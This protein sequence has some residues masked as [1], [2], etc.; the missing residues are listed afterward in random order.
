M[1]KIS[2]NYFKLNLSKYKVSLP[3]FSSPETKEEVFKIRNDNPII[4]FMHSGNN[5]YFWNG[6]LPSIANKTI[7]DKRLILKMIEES[8]VKLFRQNIG[9]AHHQKMHIH[10]IIILDEDL[11]KG[12]FKG[13]ELYKTFNI[14]FTQ[15]HLK[16]ETAIGFT[17]STK[18]SEKSNWKREDFEKNNIQFD[19]LDFHDET[20]TVFLN[21]KAKY[22]I[23]KHFNYTSKLK[24]KLDNL[25]AIQNEFNDIGE[26]IQFYILNDLDKIKLPNDLNISLIEQI[27]LPNNQI[28]YQ[29]LEQP[30]CYFFG[31]ELPRYENSHIRQKIKY[32]KPFTYDDFE[33]R[34]ISIQFILP[35][36]YYTDTLNFF[37]DVKAELKETFKINKSKIKASGKKLQSFSI[38]A[39]QK[40]FNQIKDVDLVIVVVSEEHETLPP[41]QS[42]YYFCKSE[43]MK[44]GINTQEVQIQQ[45]RK[46][47][48][49]KKN[50]K[51]NY[52]HHNFALNI[53]AKLGGM[54]WTIKPDKPKNELVIG[55]GATTDKKGQPI[56]G[57]A[58]IF[59]GDGKYLF[60]EISSITDMENYPTS[61]EKILTKSIQTAIDDEILDVNKPFH[62]MFHVF[63]EVGKNNEIKA[64]IRTVKKFSK[65]R[66]KY[67]FVHIGNGHNYRFFTYSE[68]NQRIKF[69]LKKGL[70]QNE[71]G[72]FIK[73]NDTMGFLGLQPLN[74]VFHKITIDERS[75]YFN[76][77]YV[78]RQIYQFAELSHT[79]YNKQGRPV[80]IKYPQLMAKFAE[81]FKEVN[82]F[83][84]TEI[85]M[86][87]N[88]LWFI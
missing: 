9:L 85:S 34:V 49:D 33:N 42:P 19:D 45:I 14:H 64:L 27:D 65:Y 18:I 28:E 16:D 17:V 23:A 4:H 39:Y 56:L 15:L 32:T 41:N 61:L 20:G 6:D 48:A 46:F 7:D 78:V 86:P 21:L 8:L 63:K 70:G 36:S 75:T 43:F 5:V 82:G 26:F 80:T 47:L 30:K 29:I 22:R 77:P 13:I 12:Q 2:T 38:D 84:L 1:Q 40:V 44:R 81:K 11:S 10:R 83:Y 24:I 60:G 31:S 52:T 58:S 66:F 62:L 72:T 73:I 79:S 54:A 35:E 67:T 25:N 55:I 59:R 3:F 50:G 51:A 71:R 57:L 76:L 87:D 37:E 53:Y 68:I 69:N 88:S 74:S